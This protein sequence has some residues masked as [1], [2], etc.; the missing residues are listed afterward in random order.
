MVVERTVSTLSGTLLCCSGCYL[1]LVCYSL[2]CY[3][4]MLC[5]YWTRTKTVCPEFTGISVTHDRS[6]LCLFGARTLNMSNDYLSADEILI[7][8]VFGEIETMWLEDTQIARFMGPTWGP[9]GSYEHCYQGIPDS[10]GTEDD[11]HVFRP[12]LYYSVDN[13]RSYFNESGKID[14]LNLNA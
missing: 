2:I 13:L 10:N 11:I 9:P 12:S 4:K 1:F 6:R 7:L 5:Q 3:A 8:N 14:V